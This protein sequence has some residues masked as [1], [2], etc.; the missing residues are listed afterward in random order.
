MDGDHGEG[1]QEGAKLFTK[2]PNLCG[3]IENRGA[4]QIEL[5]KNQQ[6]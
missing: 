4:T 2:R 6:I 1:E 3:A 5:E